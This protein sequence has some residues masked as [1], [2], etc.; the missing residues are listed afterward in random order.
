VGPGPAFSPSHYVIPRSV[1]L[2]VSP[3]VCVALTS[4]PTLQRGGAVKFDLVLMALALEQVRFASTAMRMPAMSPTMTEGGVASWKKSEGE[5]FAAGD[6]LLEVV[7]GALASPRLPM[8][9]LDALSWGS[10]EGSSCG[11]PL[12]MGVGNRQ[13]DHRCRSAR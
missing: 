7:S 10:C 6:V 3:R 9:S 11:E 2:R 8:M 13:G 5:S 12:L 4:P 1:S